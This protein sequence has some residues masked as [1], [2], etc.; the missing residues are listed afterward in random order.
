MDDVCDCQPKRDPRGSCQPCGSS[1]KKTMDHAFERQLQSGP[2]LK[3]V[4]AKS[5]KPR[6]FVPQQRISAVILQEVC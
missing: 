1:S 4:A 5:T 2:G 6:K 3:A